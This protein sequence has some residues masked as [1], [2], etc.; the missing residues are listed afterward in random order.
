[1]KSRTPEEQNQDAREWRNN[2]IAAL[3]GTARLR[4]EK[5]EI[6]L[7]E[8]LILADSSDTKDEELDYTGFRI[9]KR[10][11]F[12][13]KLDIGISQSQQQQQPQQYQQP[14]VDQPQQQQPQQVGQNWQ[15]P[16]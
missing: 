1:M 4:E 5:V 9:A 2:Q 12:E 16:Q 14:Q 8:K 6:S 7:E 15:V 13:F 11:N 10:A 3:N